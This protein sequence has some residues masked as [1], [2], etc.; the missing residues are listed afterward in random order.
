MKGGRLDFCRGDLLAIL[1]V[2]VLAVSTAAFFAVRSEDGENRV[3]RIYQ[4]GNLIDELPLGKDRE[5]EIAGQYRNTVTILDG[6]AAIT[7][8][9]CPGEDC[10]HSGWISGAGRSVVCLPNRVEIRIVG[11]SDVDFVVG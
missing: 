10:V 9:D 1:L 11:Q 7:D 4:D 5:I 6:K 3:V 2:V 8:S